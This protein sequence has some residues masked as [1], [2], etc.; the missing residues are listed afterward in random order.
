MPVCL[1]Q[2]RDGNGYHKTIIARKYQLYLP[3]EQQLIDEVMKEIANLDR[4]ES[5]GI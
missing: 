2:K 1:L 3:T 5:E 4:Y